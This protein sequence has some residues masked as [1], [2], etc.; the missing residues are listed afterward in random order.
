M[1]SIVIP[2]YNK[3][4][5]IVDT[6]SKLKGVPDIEIL[7]VDNNSTDNSVIL[8]KKEAEINP[9]IRLLVQKKKGVSAARNMGLEAAKG[10]YVCFLDA[11]DWYEGIGNAYD[12]LESSRPDILVFG[13]EKVDDQSKKRLSVHQ[14]SSSGYIDYHNKGKWLKKA[15]DNLIAYNVSNKIY[16]TLFLK[17]NALC[18]N[19][20]Y[21][22]LEDLS[23]F[24]NAY[25]RASRV[26]YTDRLT[27]QYRTNMIK[28][29]L[30]G[31]KRYDYSFIAGAVSAFREI[32]KG[33]ERGKCIDQIKCI[34]AA[35]YQIIIREMSI[36]RLRASLKENLF[37]N[38]KIEAEV[39]QLHFKGISCW[40]VEHYIKY[41]IASRVL[42]ISWVITRVRWKETN[43]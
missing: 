2:L 24:L 16:R 20:K 17:E 33:A 36:M 42:I 18:F 4:D 43:G 21:D 1:L 7:V 27:H 37:Y 22:R 6:L 28:G 26:E 3:E 5:Y 9:Q 39:R 34:E 19:E 15:V 10:E 8:C 40:R 30:G 11:D 31:S 12:I 25:A 38:K 13:F 35:A 41:W 32:E 29:S 14:M 23:F